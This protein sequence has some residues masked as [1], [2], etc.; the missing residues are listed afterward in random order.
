MLELRKKTNVNVKTFS[1]E[2][3]INVN[4]RKKGNYQKADYLVKKFMKN[5]CDDADN[6][7]FFFVKCFSELPENTIWMIFEKATGS[8]RV[9][10]PIKYFIGACRNL[11]NS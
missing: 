1:S 10:S 5:G 3:R 4:V 6:C 9:K 11:M 2:R 8:A 7:Y